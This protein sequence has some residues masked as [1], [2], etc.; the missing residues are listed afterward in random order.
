MHMLV[1]WMLNLNSFLM[2]SNS[3]GAGFVN[4]R[5]SLSKFHVSCMDGVYASSSI[6]LDTYLKC[7]G[8][9]LG[10]SVLDSVGAGCF[11]NLAC[12]EYSLCSID[13]L[14]SDSSCSACRSLYC[15]PSP[16]CNAYFSSFLFQGNDS[17]SNIPSLLKQLSK[18]LSDINPETISLIRGLI[19]VSFCIGL[20]II[21]SSTLSIWMM[22]FVEVLLG[23]KTLT[24][25]SIEDVDSDDEEDSSLLM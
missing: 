12:C 14:S 3:I 5:D 10:S 21:H 18:E 1:L 17:S 20:L 16:S 9:S 6:D 23:H 22:E 4:L 11:G 7:L 15:S 24:T 8:S 13:C 19:F 25:H 2:M